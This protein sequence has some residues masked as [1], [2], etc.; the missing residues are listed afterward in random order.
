MKKK[1]AG[2]K[3]ARAKRCHIDG[4]F[5]HVMARGNYGQDIFFSD[6]DRLHMS[7]LLQDGVEKYGHRI[8]AFCLM[9][10]HIHLLIQVGK[11]PLSEIMQNVAFRYSQK[12]NYKYQRNGRLFQ[13]RYKAILLDE[14]SYFKRLMRYIHM[15]P[16]RANITSSPESYIWSSHNAYLGKNKIKWLT[17]DYGLSQF[18]ST[19]H[20]ATLSYLS[21]VHEAEPPE[22][23]NELRRNFKNGQHLGSDDFLEIV[24]NK[25]NIVVEKL[26]TLENIV[27][28]ACEEFQIAEFIII[29]PSKAAEI[30]SVRAIISTIASQ[31]GKVPLVKIA[32]YMKRDPSR[33]TYLISKLSQKASE[34][35]EMQI[36]IENVKQKAYKIARSQA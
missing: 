31:I 13:G 5:Y 35:K 36:K 7:F 10:N 22:E 26:P 21:Y 2:Q 33:I 9:G 1:G 19:V 24:R 30:S 34:S 23:L 18:G 32:A 14:A 12:I 4:G 25:H 3:M 6:S 16:V 15:N 20:E 17:T 29:S 11:I 8:H 27:T 28:A